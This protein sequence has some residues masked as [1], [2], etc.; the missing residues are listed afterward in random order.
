VRPSVVILSAIAL[1]FGGSPPPLEPHFRAASPRGWVVEGKQEGRIEWM[2]FSQSTEM[3]GE[4][5]AGSAI[6]LYRVEVDR[7]PEEAG[8]ALTGEKLDKQGVR[9]RSPVDRSVKGIRWRGFEADYASESGAPRR[10]SYLYVARGKKT[11]YLFWARGPS[12]RF[13]AASPLV[14]TSLQKVSEAISG[15]EP[16]PEGFVPEVPHGARADAEME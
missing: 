9:T 10:E 4:D 16:E 3:D 1:L 13:R 11:L 14:E 7:R 2:R 12:D 15:D 8:E 5:Y 6:T